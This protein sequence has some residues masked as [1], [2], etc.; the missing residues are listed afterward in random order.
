MTT[1]RQLMTAEEF[2]DKYAGK[3]AELWY[4]EVRGIEPDGEGGAMAPVGHEHGRAVIEIGG[5]LSTFAKEHT[6]G[7]VTSEVGF[8]LE[9]DPSVTV[10]PDIAFL[11]AAKLPAAD[12]KSSYI[13]GPPTLAV[14]VVSPGDSDQE[15]HAK[16]RLYL[17]H[18]VARVWVVRPTLASVTVHR[19]DGTA[20][21]ILVD[22][23]LT[24]DDAGFTLEGF[25]LPL[26]EIFPTE[27]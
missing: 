10:A 26:G 22:G 1:A 16:V 3:K 9:R 5:A 11:E 12:R 14:E 24:S 13:Q 8:V 4:G 2:F 27:G 19:P 21:E 23:A 15:V 7:S 6:L 18:G 25:V 20:R 17:G